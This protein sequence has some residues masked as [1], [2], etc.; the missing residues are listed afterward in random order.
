MADEAGIR[1]EILADIPHLRAFAISLC[2]NVDSADDLVQDT[3]LR[4]LTHIDSFEPNTNLRGWLFRILR[5]AFY[6]EYRKR[7]HEVRDTDGI[8]ASRLTT[9]PSQ[10]GHL[11]YKDF[12]RAFARLTPS[13]REALLLV[14][15]SGFKFEDAA[16]IMGVAEGTAKSRVIRARARLAELLQLSDEDLGPDR[17]TRAVIQASL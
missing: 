11:A 5:N 2:G 7:R 15:A 6:S 13:Q 14:V 1:D 17:T 8:F 10:E 3:I 12:L 16:Q 9:H 4:A